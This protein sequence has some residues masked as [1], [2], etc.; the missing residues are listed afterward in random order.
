M[1]FLRVQKFEGAGMRL[2][3]HA[4]AGMRLHVIQ[5][6]YRVAFDLFGCIF[7]H[8]QRSRCVCKALRCG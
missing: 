2:Q 8:A 4:C 3:T 1:R 7:N 5:M 6:C